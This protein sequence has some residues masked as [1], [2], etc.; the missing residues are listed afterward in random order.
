MV[1]K[2]KA[3]IGI[4]STIAAA[5]ICGAVV[6]SIFTYP[7]TK[8][9]Q[10][11]VGF[12]KRTESYEKASEIINSQSITVANGDQEIGTVDLYYVIPESKEE[13][14]T[15]KTYYWPIEVFKDH[16]Y[17]NPPSLNERQLKEDVSKLLAGGKEPVNAHLEYNS[18][19]YEIIPE[20]EGTAYDVEAAYKKI[21]NSIK[22]DEEVCDV[23]ECIKKAEI[24]KD[25]ETLKTTADIANKMI[26]TKL[27]YE[28]GDIKLV[29]TNE[30]KDYFIMI[31]NKGHVSVDRDKVLE[32]ALKTI[33][34]KFDSVG[35]GVSLTTPDGRQI[36]ANGGSWGYNVDSEA[37]ADAIVDA[38]ENGGER[39]GEPIY[40]QNASS[41]NTYVEVDIANQKVHVVVDGKEKLV[42]DCVTGNT[43]TGHG[44]HTGAYY[45]YA[46]LTNWTMVKYNA[47]VRYWMPFNGD[48]GL[49][50][51]SWRSS[52]GGSIYKTNGSHGCTNLSYD[53]AKF[54][55]D[56]CPQGTLVIVH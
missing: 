32:Y 51:A 46:K 19:Q 25:N 22:Q 1:R 47:F 14:Y 4:V 21:V 6:F 53:T 34:G 31:D 44:T 8:I 39:V 49:H 40:K 48:E 27:S 17:E 18:G 7:N 20:T 3:I 43:S 10:E 11:K 29:P 9:F 37:E 50:D 55:Y 36:S 28:R 23:K 24:T 15:D 45:I 16:S 12:C 13:V 38:M 33:S 54:I 30:D 26:N 52:F 2:K 35:Q 5:Y 42:S 56:N 41:T